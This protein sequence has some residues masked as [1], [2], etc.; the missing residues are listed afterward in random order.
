MGG[1]LPSAAF[2]ARRRI[3]ACVQNRRIGA[4]CFHALQA[5]LWGASR[6]VLLQPFSIFRGDP[7]ASLPQCGWCGSS[8]YTLSLLLWRK[9]HFLMTRT[10]N[11][12][13]REESWL[14]LTAGKLEVWM[15]IV[16]LNVIWTNG[17]E[18][19]VTI[20]S[21]KS[22]GKACWPAM[23]WGVISQTN[24]PAQLPGS[25]G[26]RS[27]QEAALS[28]HSLC[29]SLVRTMVMRAHCE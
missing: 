10:Q 22:K 2:L 23:A 16:Q 6:M 5:L 20:V 21:K 9:Q 18:T 7:A 28:D 12:F 19:K 8:P 13:T 25:P 11:L 14:S 27:S 3:G 17:G 26:Q 24:T 1:W 15:F 4:F 29:L